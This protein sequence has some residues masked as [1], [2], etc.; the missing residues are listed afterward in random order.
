MNIPAVAYTVIPRGSLSRLIGSKPW[1]VETCHPGGPSRDAVA[2]HRVTG[3]YVPQ[4]SSMMSITVER[5]DAAEFLRKDADTKLVGKLEE[6]RR[7]SETRVELLFY[8]LSREQLD[9]VE[10]GYGFW[11]R[12]ESVCSEVGRV[13]SSGL[14]LVTTQ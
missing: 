10:M 11:R 12:L 2:T 1:C 14:V 7:L 4:L 9:D 8:S 13:S 3:K 6:A 5:N